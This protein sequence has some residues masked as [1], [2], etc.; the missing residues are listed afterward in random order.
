MKVLCSAIRYQS[1]E[2]YVFMQK[3]MCLPSSSTLRK[4]LKSIKLDLG[5]C[6]P[7]FDVLKKSA[8]I[9]DLV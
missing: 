1:P 8:T 9:S 6:L 5:I 2:A 4:P 3:I 7:V